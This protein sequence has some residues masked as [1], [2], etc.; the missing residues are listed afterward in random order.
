[1]SLYD[2][3]R[4]LPLVVEG[5]ALEGLVAE[6]SSGFVRQTTVVHLQGAGEEGIGEDVTYEG[7]EHD[8]AAARGADLPLAGTW[9]ID[10]LSRHLDE[11][12]LFDHEPDQHA[13]L[14]Y[15]RWAYESAALDLAL[16]QGGRSL[17][18]AVGEEVDALTF[19]VSTRLGEVPTTERVRA[20]LGLYP[21]VRFKL[22]A[23]P[24][25][26][27]ELVAELAELGCVDSVD[28]KGQYRGTSVDTVPDPALYRRVIEGLPDA[29]L[30]DPALTPETEE[31]LDPVAERVT[32]D[33]PIHSVA[34]IE[35]LRWP[36]RT[37]NVKPSRFGTI[38]RLF[39][40]Y[41]HC[42]ARGIEAYGGGQFEL[43]PGR[44]QI[45]LLAALFHPH[46][47]NDVAP[48]GYNATQPAPGLPASP[49][50]VEPRATGFLAL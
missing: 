30:E 18:A 38:E 24:A 41:D 14:D 50:V 17:G 11:L 25:W 46:T 45:Q 2:A 26:T 20:W 12:P 31:I 10:T 40:A 4:D 8:R 3:V 16:R 39:A 22:D 29:W 48:G 1:V 34:D 37:V 43:G 33:A 49:L 13:Y 42:A 6:V 36:P 5:Y 9:T 44:G 7:A 28:F 21:G 15:R 23:T 47:P 19:V 35:A 27:D 32:W